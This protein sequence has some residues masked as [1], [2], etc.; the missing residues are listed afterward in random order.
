MPIRTLSPPPRAAASASSSWRGDCRTEITKLFCALCPLCHL[1]Q[2]VRTDESQKSRPANFGLCRL[3]GCSGS[4][5]LTHSVTYNLAEKAPPGRA[6]LSNRGGEYMQH[7][8]R[9]PISQ[10]PVSEL[11]P[12]R[13]RGYCN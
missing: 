1:A 6:G 3:R 4:V 5:D 12:P 9:A 8:P 13:R 11:G 10:A 2:H 7:S